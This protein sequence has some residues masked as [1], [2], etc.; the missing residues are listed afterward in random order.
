M[1][2]QLVSFTILSFN[3]E[4]GV[5]KITLE[6]VIKCLSKYLYVRGITDVSLGDIRLG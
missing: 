3:K 2:E 5:V 4:S 6:L 1:S